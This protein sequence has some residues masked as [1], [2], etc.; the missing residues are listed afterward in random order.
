[1]EC[2]GDT[3][4]AMTFLLPL[5]VLAGT[6]GLL[7]GYVALAASK[8]ASLHR[9]SG[10]MFV[11][12]MVTLSITGLLMSA[13]GGV[14]PEM[15]IVTALVTCYLVVTGM[16]TVTPRAAWSSR[17]DRG[18]MILAFA[19]V[20]G[21]VVLAAN[22]IGKGG[23]RAGMAYPLVMFGGISLAAAIGDR[24][25]VRNGPL[26]GAARLQRHLWRV[27]VALF[28]SAL[29]LISGRLPAS[30]RVPALNAAGVIV[31]V[32][33]IFYWKWRLRASRPLHRAV[34]IIA[35]EAA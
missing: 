16:A 15:N 2:R 7:S 9:K 21:C 17:F 35:P 18:A 5:H 23:A 29:A 32:A 10:L 11:Y 6:L 24:R 25:V 30:L 31:P 8:G 14:A 1:M 27:C 26:K 22:S 20:A 12:V 13:S 3:E 4:P 28:I 34:P 33:A 19:L